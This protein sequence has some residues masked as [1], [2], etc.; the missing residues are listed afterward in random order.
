MEGVSSAALFDWWFRD[1]ASGRVVI[2]QFPNAAVSVWLVATVLHS[3]L[4]TLHHA[5]VLRWLASGALVAWGVDELLR[6]AN[7]FRRSLGAFAVGY[8]L[9]V[10]VLVFRGA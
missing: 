2:A 3:I 1:R 5:D 10:L 6:G 9:W 4:G 8:E 7:P